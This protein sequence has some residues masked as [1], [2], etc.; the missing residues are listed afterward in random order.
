MMMT[1]FMTTYSKT[2]FACIMALA[3]VGFLFLP[4]PAHADCTDP[5]GKEG[6]IRFNNAYL[7]FQGCNGTDWVAF[8]DPSCPAGDGCDPCLTGPIGTVCTSDGAVYAGDTVGGARMY[9]ATANEAALKYGGANIDLN[10][11]NPAAAPELDDDGLVNTNWL[12]TSG[13]GDH[14]AA[15]ACRDRGTDWY[16]PAIDELR[17]IYNNWASLGSANLPAPAIGTGFRSSSEASSFSTDV[18][19][20]NDIPGNYIQGKTGTMAVIRCVRR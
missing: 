20:T 18:L 4:A 11:S 13:A 16:L 2:N 7:V 9:V 1:R 3:L 8:H 17:E 10:G 19:V 14:D 12:L 5:A 6:E 15:Q